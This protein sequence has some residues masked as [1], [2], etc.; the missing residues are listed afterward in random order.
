MHA[1]KLPARERVGQRAGPQ[2]ADIFREHG[3]AYARAHDLSPERSKVLYDLRTCRTA[4]LGGHLDMCDTCDFS[5][6]SYNSCRNRHCPTC[7][8]LQQLRW[9]QSRNARIL[10]THYFHVVFTLPAALRPLAAYR[11]RVVYDLF[12]DAVRDTLQTLAADHLGA[13][14]G[15]TAVLH[16]WNRRMLFHPHLHCIVTGGG[17]A[18]DGSTWK[19]ARSRFLFPVKVMGKLLRGKLV[20]A[21]KDAWRKGRLLFEKP[22]GSDL[23]DDDDFARLVNALFRNNWVVYAK[24]PFGGP[25]QVI[26]YLG[27]YTHQVAISSYRLVAANADK[28]TFRTR[29]DHTVTITP[30][31]FIRRFLL[32][33]LPKGF[34][35]IRHSGLF[36][37][38][39]VHTHLAT[40]RMLLEP[41]QTPDTSEE[42][43][44]SWDQLL[45]RILDFDPWV[46][47]A[48]ED[49]RLFRVAV[50]PPDTPSALPPTILDS[51]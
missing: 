49:G 50:L 39:S 14:L 4:R 12:F 35:K 26:K 42:T 13:Q 17:L 21:L 16:T 6:P 22:D 30:S 38:S 34:R 10:P 7:Q 46:C 5:R 11:P 41:D 23:A 43:E 19:S 25:H 28:V 29:E 31:E 20:D 2:V 33:V 40:A 24:R 15:I 8:T 27:L 37:S 3:E 47:P 1:H 44:L 18:L 9:I 32:H 51:S 45:Q 48:C 36:A